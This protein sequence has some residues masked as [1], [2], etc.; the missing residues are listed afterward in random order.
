MS[1]PDPVTI[2]EIDQDYCTRT[3]GTSPCLA[4]LT[5]TTVRKCYNTWATCKYKAAYNKGV[6]TL[7]FVTKNS[8]MPVGENYIPALVSASG[9]SGTVNVAGSDDRMF[10]LGVRTTVA[11]KMVDFADSDTLTDKYFAERISGAAQTDEGGYSPKD[12][13]SFWSKWKSRNPNYAGRPMRIIQGTLSGGVMTPLTTRHYVI[14]EI[15]GPDSSGNVTIHGADILN[16]ADDK[17]SIAPK[18]SRG[19][20]SA[21]ITAVET[22]VTLLPAGVGAEYAA[23]GWAVIGSEIVAFDRSGD[24]LT[25]TRGQRGTVAATH[26]TDDTVQETFSCRRQRIDSVIYSLLVDYAG[27]SASYIPYSDWQ[28]EVLRWANDLRLTADICKP[29]G[30]AKLIGELAILGISIWWDDVAQKIQLKVNRPPDTDT[31]VDITDSGHIIKAAQEDRDDDRLTRVS[32]WT[33]Q[34]DPTKGVTKENFLRQRLLIDVDAENVNNYNGQR[35]KEIYCRWLNHGAD[36]VVRVLSKRLLNR[37][38]RQPVLYELTVDYKDNVGLADVIRMD[39]RIAADD[40]GNSLQQ[41]MQVIKREDAVNGHKI[42]ITAQKFT[43]DQ[44]YGFITEDGRP[45]YASSTDLQK[46]R[47]CYIVDEGTLLFG[48]GTGPYLMI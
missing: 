37:F 12:R 19:Y 38:N 23:S 18:S 5:G 30:V 41:L 15:D 24:V 26:A 22:S 17:K 47:G 9:R 7:S 11:A 32:F 10:A 34:I 40:T 13:G 31:V 3:F 21:D 25:I 20:L 1:Q 8:G 39:S 16:L 42:N 28:E 35:V 48:D 33:V 43:F 45:V 29:E 36:S 27:I 14:T 2:V 46:S 44:R 4:A 6:N